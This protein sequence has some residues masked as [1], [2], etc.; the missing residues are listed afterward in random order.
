MEDRFVC[1][2]ILFALYAKF[3]LVK[4]FCWDYNFSLDTAKKE[5]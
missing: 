1:E 2:I 4:L 3:Y 5:K